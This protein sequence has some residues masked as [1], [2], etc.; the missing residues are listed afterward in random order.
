[1][2]DEAKP[3]QSVPVVYLVMPR[4]GPE[5]VYGAGSGLFHSAQGNLKV[6]IAEHAGS[7]S[8]RNHNGAWYDALNKRDWGQGDEK[9]THFAMIHADVCPPPGWLD[10]YMA[11][12]QKYDADVLSGVISF[13][14]HSGLT[15][16]A[17]ENP[18]HLR[19]PGELWA[20]RRLTKY[21]TNRLP[22][23]FSIAD[24]DTPQSRLLFNTGL[25]LINLRGN[26]Q[27]DTDFRFLYRKTRLGADLWSPDGT[28]T[29]AGYRVFE[30]R[31]EDWEL[32]RFCADRKLR[33]Y[34]TRKV[35][36]KHVGPWAWSNTEVL[37]CPHCKECLE[38]TTD[39]LYWN[40]QTARQQ[41]IVS[42]AIASMVTPRL[43]MLEQKI[44]GITKATQPAVVEKQPADVV[45]SEA[46]PAESM[47]YMRFEMGE[48]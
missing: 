15:S 12:M 34:C 41:D 40:R 19:D 5:I 8:Q 3:E 23:T 9:P 38:Q 14:D 11:E 31:S 42:R 2:P 27:D 30:M 32:A 24:T 22:E 25:L 18:D 39:T 20:P 29:P 21:E 6:L 7:A 28:Y 16:V 17:I 26:W 10:V 33:V 36:I 37:T 48:G 35:H 4:A 13:R 43:V 1:M 44:D 46:K 45:T 47:D